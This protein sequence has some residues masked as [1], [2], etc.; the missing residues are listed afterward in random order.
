MWQERTPGTWGF[1]ET[2]C[3]GRGIFCSTPWMASGQSGCGTNKNMRLAPVRRLPS[4]FQCLHAKLGS[5]WTVR[6]TLCLSTTSP[7]MAPSSTPSRTVPSLDLCGLSSIPVSMMAEEMQPLWPSVLWAWSD[8][9]PLTV[10]G[11]LWSLT[12]PLL[13]TLP[14]F[15]MN[16]EPPLSLQRCQDTSKPILTRSHWISMSND[17]QYLSIPALGSLWF[18]HETDYLYLVQIHLDQPKHVSAFFLWLKFYFLPAMSR[19]LLRSLFYLTGFAKGL[20]K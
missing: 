9:D 11:S 17:L 8:R 7:T 14:Y 1:V 5:S 19:P 15:P 6:P 3:R 12:H 4:T 16:S 18:L 20:P 13:I 2:L 10:D